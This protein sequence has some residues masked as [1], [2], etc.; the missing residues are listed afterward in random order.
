MTD[1]RLRSAGLVLSLCGIALAGYLTWVHYADAQAVCVGG[2]GSCE[3]VQTSDY[4]VIAG[5]PVALIGLIGYG[6][7]AAAFSS[8]AEPA[9]SVAAFLAIGGLGFSAYLTY[10]ELFT[11]EA[12][13]QWCVASAVLMSAIAGIAVARF[14]RPSPTETEVQ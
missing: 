1:A 5:V 7:L 12:I 10:V 13:C 3:R 11:L 9:V 8:R 6:A 14:L 4:A 2:G